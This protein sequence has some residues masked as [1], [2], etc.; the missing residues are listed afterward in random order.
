MPKPDDLACNYIGGAWRASDDV[1]EN[2][3]PSD[4]DDL[5]GVFASASQQD[6]GDAV[7]AA[8][9]AFPAWSTT[10]PSR[11]AELLKKVGDILEMR[12]DELGALLSREEGKTLGEGTAEVSRAAQIFHFFA[13]ECLRLSGELMA[14]TRE[15]VDVEIL[16]EPVGVIGLITPWNYPLAIPAWKVAPALAYG[17]CVVLKPAELTPA[18]AY[19]LAG[20]IDAVGFPPGVF[21]LVMGVGA[22]VGA[23]LTNSPD[24]DAISFTGSE[25]VGRRIAAACGATKKIQL[26]LGGSNPFVVMDDANIDQAVAAAIN[27][28][29]ASTGQ[30]CTATSRLI[31]HEPIFET[32]LGKFLAQADALRVGHALDATTQMG[33]VASEAQLRANLD[34]LELGHREGATVVGGDV[35]QLGQRGYYQK[36]AIFL[37]ASSSMRITQEE[38]FGPCVSIMTAPDLETAIALANDTRFGLSSGIATTSLSHAKRFQRSAQAGVVTVNLP[39]GGI[40]HHAPF[41]GRKASSLGP[42][43]QGRYAVEFYTTVKTTYVFSG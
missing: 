2:R 31:L 12:R 3:N 14:S 43:E 5:V 20:A 11:R 41:G 24:V 8:R 4:L 7:E 18:L 25:A 9:R 29:F 37:D 15:A 27:G 21:N 34:Y 23:A 26:E 13:G 32:F 33:P 40:D 1:L 35:L 42:R 39:T 16:R 30:R 36:P 22:Q 6:V 17:N 10:N 19:A 28:A 38:I